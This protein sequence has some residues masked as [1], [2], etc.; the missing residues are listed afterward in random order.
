VPG[1]DYT[2]ALRTP[3]YRRVDIGLAYRLLDEDS[4]ENKPAFWRN[5]K[6][7]WVGIDV[8]NLLDIKNV[9]S[10]SWFS[11]VNGYQYAVPDKLTGRQFNLKLV[12][13]F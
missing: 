13:E 5:F 4:R 7:I 8:F 3:P 6:N 1:N 12:A 2:T 11:D 9:S 10:Y